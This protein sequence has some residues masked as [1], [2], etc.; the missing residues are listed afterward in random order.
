M[1]GTKNLTFMAKMT[2]WRMKQLILW[3]FFHKKGLKGET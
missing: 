3:V 2:N 1:N